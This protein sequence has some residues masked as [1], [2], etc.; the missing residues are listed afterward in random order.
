MRLA[1]VVKLYDIPPELVINY[2][3]TAQ[4]LVPTAKRCKT[5]VPTG[6]RHVAVLGLGDKCQYTL[7]IGCTAS[8]DAFSGSNDFPRKNRKTACPLSV[9]I[10]GVTLKTGF[11]AI[12]RI[13]GPMWIQ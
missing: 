6:T 5:L 10:L 8:G 13:I 4:H 2:D 3:Q 9:C 1:I 12:R 7:D 11:G